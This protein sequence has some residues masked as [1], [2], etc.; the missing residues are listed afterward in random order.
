MLTIARY[1]CIPV[2]CVFFLPIGIQHVQV[3]H[4]TW[5]ITLYHTVKET[6]SAV[7]D[8]ADNAYQVPVQYVYEHDY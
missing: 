4:P 7:I 1:V 8:S 2:L 6:S 3:L 5:H